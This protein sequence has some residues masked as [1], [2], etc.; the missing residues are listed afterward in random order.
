MALIIPLL[1]SP[2]ERQVWSVCADIARERRPQGT[3][4]QED[5]ITQNGDDVTQDVVVVKTSLAEIASRTGLPES[6][7][8][9][10]A[11]KLRGRDLGWGTIRL[12]DL[13]SHPS[14]RRDDLDG[15]TAA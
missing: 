12:N 14:S 9:D 8:R 7:V 1:R 13:G 15:G 3:R 10:A 6:A 4:V 2:I 5:E 11:K